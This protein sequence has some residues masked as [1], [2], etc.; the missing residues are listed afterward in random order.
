MF[1]MIPKLIH[2]SWFSGEPYPQHIKELMATWK[3]YLPDY[4]F[5]LWDASKLATVNNTFA[6]EAVSVR[7]WAFAADFIRLYAVYH[8]GGIWLDTDIEMFKSFDD[9]LGD[10]MFI[11]R[12]WFTHYYSPQI[13]FLTSHC[14]GAEPNHPF[15]KDCLDYYSI[16]HFIRTTNPKYPQSLRFDMTI[17]P[18]VQAN[19][20]RTYGYNWLERINEHQ[21]LREEIHVYPH[22][23][24]DAPGYHDM[25]EVV[26]IH[27]VAGSWRPNNEGNVPD[28]SSTNPKCK[29]FVY[30]FDKV[31]NGFLKKNGYQLIRV[32]KE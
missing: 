3:I 24:F 1:D 27:R 12:E 4:E 2:Y 13:C 5:M 29:G 16:R 6:N 32:A 14:F 18:E 8:Y 23:F 20:A 19:I 25:S 21:Y 7:K 31:M 17:L 11:G 30:Y 10:R 28:F 9:F 15:L 26:C 22:Q